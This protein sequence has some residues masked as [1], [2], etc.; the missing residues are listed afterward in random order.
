M[1]GLSSRKG[2]GRMISS[3]FHLP[4]DSTSLVVW[5]PCPHAAA[6]LLPDRRSGCLRGAGHIQPRSQE[7]PA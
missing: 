4:M 2:R 5:P 7:R 1:P 6:F 3:L